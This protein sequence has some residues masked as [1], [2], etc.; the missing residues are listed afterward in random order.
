MTPKAELIRSTLIKAFVSQTIINPFLGYFA[1]DLFKYFGMLALDAPLPS[2]F[3]IACCLTAGMKYLFIYRLI[4]ENCI[5]NLNKFESLYVGYFF[6]VIGFYFTHRLLHVKGLYVRFHK[7][8]H[9]YAGTIGIMLNNQK[10]S[11]LGLSEI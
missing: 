3:N 7:Q 9:D 2:S 8:H 11:Q 4:L 10:I 1:Y 5:H 6:N